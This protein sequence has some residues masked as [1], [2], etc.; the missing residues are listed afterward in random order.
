LGGHKWRGKGENGEYGRC[1]KGERGGSDQVLPRVESS[2]HVMERRV[3]TEPYWLVKGENILKTTDGRK[4][5]SGERN[6][7]GI[8]DRGDLE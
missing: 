8:L 1:G 6:R 2:I 5:C 7:C 3:Y 4:A